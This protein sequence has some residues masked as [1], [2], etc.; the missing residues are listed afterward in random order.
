MYWV[1]GIAIA[2]LPM[3]YFGGGEGEDVIKKNNLGW[4]AD[5]SDYDNL[6]T[7][8]STIKIESLTLEKKQEIQKT[9]E[10]NFDFIDQLNRL[11]NRL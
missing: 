2:L 7:I 4:I 11:K 8:I 6:N 10:N 1:G 9:A 3:L 5:S